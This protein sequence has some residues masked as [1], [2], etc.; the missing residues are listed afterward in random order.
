TVF[1]TGIPGGSTTKLVCPG[2]PDIVGANVVIS[3]NGSTLTA[4]FDLV[5]A[6][7]GQ[8]TV[9]ITKPDGTS[10]NVPKPFTIEQGGSPQLQ[11]EIVGLNLIRFGRE[12]T[13][14]IVVRNTGN[15]DAQP[16]IV[17]VAVPST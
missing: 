10:R 1:G 8:C 4:T 6:T 13:Y 14:Y 9:A 2:Q 17:S 16:G 7:P 12:Q 11:V 3:T 5:G 15:V